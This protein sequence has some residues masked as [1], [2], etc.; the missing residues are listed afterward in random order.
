M[1]KR[2]FRALAC[3]SSELRHLKLR[4]WHAKAETLA[5]RSGLASHAK[6]MLLVMRRICGDK[7]KNSAKL[8][9]GPVPGDTRKSEEINTPHKDIQP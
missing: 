3:R 4:A 2:N 5:C 6:A 8:K 9:H 7:S 1:A